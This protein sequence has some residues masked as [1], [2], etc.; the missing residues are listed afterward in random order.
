MRRRDVGV[1]M[2]SCV[3]ALSAAVVLTAMPAQVNAA[4]TKSVTVS[5]Q[6][7]LNAALKNSKVGTITIKTSKDIKI[8]IP[9]GKFTSKSVVMNASKASLTNN[10]TLKGMTIK[11][12]KIVTEKADNNK[13]NITDKGLR[14]IVAKGADNS[15]VSIGTKDAKVTV[16][17]DG[18]V[19]SVTVNKK[20]S[21]AVTGTTTKPVSVTSTVAGTGLI[22]A[23]KANVSLK[24]ST[25]VDVR[26][27]ADLGTVTAYDNASLKVAKGAKIS[28]FNSTGDKA[29]V[30]LVTNGAV[31]NVVLK[32]QATVTITGEP[33]KKV[34][35]TNNASGSLVKL[36][37][38]ADVK[39]TQPTTVNAYKGSEI[40][41]VTATKDLVLNVGSGAKVDTVLASK[42]VEVNANKGS[43]VGTVTGSMDVE[44]NVAVGA[45]VDTVKSQGEDAKVTVS[46]NGTVGDV[47]ID[48]KADV[49]VA[50]TTTTPVNVTSNAADAVVSVSAASNITL[51]EKATVNV[52]EGAKVESLTA[53]KDVAVNV[54]AKAEVAE[55]VVK[56]EDAKVDVTAN[57]TVGA[58]T[59]D[60]KAE[61]SIKGETDS[62][63]V[64]NANVESA[65]INTEVKT[66]VNANAN[67]DITLGEG[68]EGSKV[69]A[70]EDVNASV[71][72]ETKEDVT[73]TD[74][75]GKD[76]T[77]DS[78]STG[79]TQVVEP[80]NPPA[81][82]PPYYFVDTI[83]MT[84]NEV[85]VPLGSTEQ[86]KVNILP[87]YATNQIVTWESEN[88]EVATVSSTGLVTPV[89]PTAP[90]T[91]G[92]RETKITATADGKTATCT[93]YVVPTST[94]ATMSKEGTDG[95]TTVTSY[96]SLSDAVTAANTAD[97]QVTLK[98]CK[99]ITDVASTISFMNNTYGVILDLNGHSI[100][101]SVSGTLISVGLDKK[102]GGNNADISGAEIENY[103][104]QKANVTITDYSETKGTI[105]NNNTS[106]KV[107]RVNYLSNLVLEGGVHITSSMA[108]GEGSQSAV[109]VR[110]DER[111]TGAGA[112]KESADKTSLIVE[113]A[114]IDNTTYGINAFGPVTV[115]VNGGIIKSN[116]PLDNDPNYAIGGNG[117]HDANEDNGGTVIN[118][119]GGTISGGARNA[120]IYQPQN[121]TLNITGGTITGCT[122]MDIKSGIVNISGN[123]EI[124]VDKTI[125]TE[126]DYLINKD[127]DGVIA[128]NCAVGVV[129]R[130]GYG[131]V[132]VNITGG[133]FNGEVKIIKFNDT[134]NTYTINNNGGNFKSGLPSLAGNLSG[135]RYV[136]NGNVITQQ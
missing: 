105:K 109:L 101:G 111:G 112:S 133:T 114:I 86:L 64:V 42:A 77:V 29:S 23:S 121:G 123:A 59:V 47:V 103:N 30:K 4:P 3:A 21:V 17:A 97:E 53:A 113:N 130:S 136:L 95:K 33:T 70:G 60:A 38:N 81:Y 49:K 90:E 10:G 56:G 34:A 40:G 118:I 72:N 82:Y 13:I 93:V 43:E 20:A 73:V 55:V 99:N 120:G 22:L 129:E 48:A 14:L 75:T 74:S 115:T 45:K 110:G 78:G 52:A 119:N 26:K 57:G 107:I 54:D 36:A 100:E 134:E 12:A 44:V 11:S 124:N 69:V 8:S 122:G 131:S 65:K 9:K 89:Q 18:K 85:M 108:S 88:P 128:C 31:G 116:S 39:A 25:N 84:R 19:A 96:T 50:G 126:A 94:V 16:V 6:K 104:G 83:T 5:T 67:V 106:A 51:N 71:K 7:S 92:V 35:V 27:G 61:V 79:D 127:G 87:T 58:V 62:S 24:N 32:K 132:Q 37:V 91:T 80:T 98:L 1:I 135:N 125:Y 46:A 117:L 102:V 2:K 68:A 66:E 63:V 28:T 15:K 41:K 76:T